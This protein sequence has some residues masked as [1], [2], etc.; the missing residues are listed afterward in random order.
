MKKNK[1]N[2]LDVIPQHNPS[3]TYTVNEE[4]FVVI[5]MKHKGFYNR[6]AQKIFKKPSV[7]HVTLEKFGSYIYS[8]IDGNK[9]VY[10]ISQFV[11]SKFGKEAEPL[12]ERLVIYMRILKNNKFIL[13]KSKEDK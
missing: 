3:C 2:F 9:T 10:D 11:K 13:Y 1:E 7:S 4:G 5:D 12:F 6:I 8:V